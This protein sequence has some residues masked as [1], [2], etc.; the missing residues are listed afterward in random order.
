MYFQGKLLY[1]FC[2]HTLFFDYSGK[3]N[4]YCRYA[5]NIFDKDNNG[6]L[7]FT[8]YVL[9]MNVHESDD[10]ESSLALVMISNYFIQKEIFFVLYR[11]LVYLIMINRNILIKKKSYI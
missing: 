8:E 1:F 10:L 2:R 9:A 4:N 7:N 11:H 3:V 6:T 5:F